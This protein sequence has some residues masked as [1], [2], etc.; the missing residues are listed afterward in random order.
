M[1]INSKEEA[2]GLYVEGMNLYIRDSKYT[3]EL[4]EMTNTFRE[5][6][7]NCNHHRKSFVFLYTNDRLRRN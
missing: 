6:A 3:P 4:L 5:V 7:V 1:D 2:T